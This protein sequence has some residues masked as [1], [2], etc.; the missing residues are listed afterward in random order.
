MYAA[1]YYVIPSPPLTMLSQAPVANTVDWPIDSRGIG[2]HRILLIFWETNLTTATASAMFSASRTWRELI[3][4]RKFNT[5]HDRKSASHMFSIGHRT[6]CCTAMP[7]N[8]FLLQFRIPS[9]TSRGYKGNR[10]ETKAAC[11]CRVD[12]SDTVTGCGKTYTFVKSA[13]IIFCYCLP[14]SLVTE[15]CQYHTTVLY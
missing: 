6:A 15:L 7:L 5:S 1:T 14:Q 2:C 13:Q 4:G 9:A 8:T 3:S 11:S 12:Y 10:L